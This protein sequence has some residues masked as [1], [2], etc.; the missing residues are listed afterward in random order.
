MRAG[1]GM[2]ERTALQ[3]WVNFRAAQRLAILL[4]G[5]G[6]VGWRTQCALSAVRHILSE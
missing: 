4:R 2:R 5:P 6:E 3:M 1:S